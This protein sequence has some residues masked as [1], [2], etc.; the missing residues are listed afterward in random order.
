MSSKRQGVYLGT[1]SGA[2][3]SKTGGVWADGSIISTHLRQSSTNSQAGT[4][5][6]VQGWVEGVKGFLADNQLG[7]D[8]VL[9]AGL[10]IPGPYAGP[11]V[12]GRAANLPAS[13]EGWNFQA[14][15]AAALS[16]AAGR[17]VP[18]VA[19]NDGNYGGVG[20]AQQTLAQNQ[21]LVMT[22][23]TIGLTWSGPFAIATYAFRTLTSQLES[24][25]NA[26]QTAAQI[27]REIVTRT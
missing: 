11:G 17:P 23:G 24:L 5:A 12:L 9:G 18:L 7:W 2:T 6:V 8:Q 21:N 10:A 3:T 20:E 4:A 27:V 16:A 13:F 19:G 15:Y 1:D 14:E 25:A 22:I 26:R